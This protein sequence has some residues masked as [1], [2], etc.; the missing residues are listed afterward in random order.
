MFNKILSYIPD[1]IV[2]IGKFVIFVFEAYFY[3]L[4]TV[5]IGAIIDHIVIL[6]RCFQ[7]WL[8]K[9]LSE[10]NLYNDGQEEP[11]RVVLSTKDSSKNILISI[12]K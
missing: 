5:S 1:S 8:R 6:A 3:F 12:K 4:K 10:F 7:I 11:N 2:R 9:V